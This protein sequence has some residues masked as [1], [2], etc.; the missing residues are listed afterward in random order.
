MSVLEGSNITFD[1][2]T[3]ENDPVPSVTSQWTFNDQLLSSMNGITL[4]LYNISFANLDRTKAGVYK[5]VVSND[6]GSVMSNL[7][8]DV[9]C[10]SHITYSHCF[11]TC[12]QYFI[13]NTVY[14]P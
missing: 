2:E 1:F 5:I 6:A 9:Q 11:H 10:E 8:L 12:K 3:S 13:W 7:T 14:R 4:E